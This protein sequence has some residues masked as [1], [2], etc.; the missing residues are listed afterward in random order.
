MM[1]F[2]ED[3]PVHLLSKKA[4]I[5]QYRR[6]GRWV[7]FGDRRVYLRSNWEV[8]FAE[9][10]EMLKKGGAIK[11]WEYEPKTF[12]FMEIKRGVR[13]Y[14]PDFMVVDNGDKVTWYEVKGFMDGRSVTKLKR[15]KKYYPDEQVRVIDRDW[16]VRN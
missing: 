12:W 10:L 8:K 1:A 7:Q 3:A 6:C 5:T 13:S 11:S 4:P 9:Y 16:F 15:M 2:A 14:K